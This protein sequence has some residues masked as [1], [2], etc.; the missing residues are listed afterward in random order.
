MALQKTVSTEH[1]LQ[2]TDAYHRVEALTLISKTSMQYHVR[3]Y[4]SVD[5][6]FFTEE[7]YTSS[8]DISGV[9]PIQQAYEHIK[10]LDA[11][12]DAEDV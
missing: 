11:F 12:S 10:T 8:Y 5:N 6:P 1:G 7:T 3:S 9:N 4:V 2:A